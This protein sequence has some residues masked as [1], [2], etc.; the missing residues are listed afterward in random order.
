MVAAVLGSFVARP[1]Q[2]RGVHAAWHAGHTGAGGSWVCSPLDRCFLMCA[3]RMAGVVHSP[4]PPVPLPRMRRTA[5]Q[6]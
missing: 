1:T 2:P 4:Q 5:G 3:H 6:F